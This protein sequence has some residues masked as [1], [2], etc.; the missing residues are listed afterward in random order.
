ML[1]TPLPPL[2][3]SLRLRTALP[4]LGLLAA[5]GPLAAAQSPDTVVFPFD[6]CG[7][8]GLYASDGVSYPPGGPLP[9]FAQGFDLVDPNWCGGDPFG[10]PAPVLRRRGGLLGGSVEYQLAGRPFEIYVLLPS[11]QTT[12]T[13][14]A[15][16][17]P[18][19]P[20][21]LN[22][23]IE[24]SSLWAIGFMDGGGAATVSLPLPN[25]AALSAQ[26]LHAQFLSVS[27]TTFDPDRISNR[28]A[29]RLHLPATPV[30]SASLELDRLGR[31]R[32]TALLDGRVL[33]TGGTKTVLDNFAADSARV[34]LYDPAKEAF[35]RAGSTLSAPRIEHTATLLADGRV[36][37]CGGFD[38]NGVVTAAAELFDPATGL[39]T[40]LADLATPR[41]F[42]AAVRLGDGRVLLAGG[43][44]GFNPAIPFVAGDFLLAT[45]LF[46]PATGTFQPGPPLPTG[47][48]HLAGSTLPDGDGLFTGGLLRNLGA[49]GTPLE[50]VATSLRFDAQTDAWSTVSSLPA[51]RSKHAQLTLADGRVAVIGGEKIGGSGAG[52]KAET[53]RF[54]PL[55]GFWTPTASLAFARREPQVLQVDGLGTDKV[56][57]AGGFSAS[58][59][60]ATLEVSP[61][62]LG[63]FQVLGSSLLPRPGVAIAPVEDRGRVLLT[64]NTTSFFNSAAEL[65][66]P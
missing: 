7:A 13:P 56:F 48:A 25:V 38:E 3:T 54:D 57:V 40:S 1:R 34:D 64:G 24:L 4:A 66:R 37:L 65:V 35:Y 20:L 59:S 43:V 28:A 61:G 49:Q 50:S 9:L 55:T 21:V 33:L 29:V 41:A 12:P 63:G 23:G 31:H 30:P 52:V 58:A 51:A 16:A 10:A 5:S 47:V 15:L 60:I 2:R 45:E 46:D 44:L 27:P 18:G 19:S 6:A 42:H 53:F 17:A 32:A 36:L 14:V 39:V 22:V 62:T 11:F 26:V 8:T